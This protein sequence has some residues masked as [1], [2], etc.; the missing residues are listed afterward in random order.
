MSN[1]I[2]REGKTWHEYSI[3]LHAGNHGEATKVRFGPRDRWVGDDYW[4][5]VQSYTP[6]RKQRAY[7]LMSKLENRKRTK[8]LL[9]ETVRKIL[10]QELGWTKR[11]TQAMENET[12]ESNDTRL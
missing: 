4:W 3:C 9:Y 7:L 8:S 12:N 10:Y 2:I 5:H 6:S 11:V 1:R